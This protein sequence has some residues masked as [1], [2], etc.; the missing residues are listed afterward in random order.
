MIAAGRDAGEIA[1]QEGRNVQSAARI[2]D[3]G[4]EKN[5]AADAVAFARTPDDIWTQFLQ[6]ARESRKYHGPPWNLDG[7]GHESPACLGDATDGVGVP[8]QGASTL[9]LACLRRDHRHDE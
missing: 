2:E 5:L 8:R 7:R 3:L 4:V 1:T 6:N 9:L